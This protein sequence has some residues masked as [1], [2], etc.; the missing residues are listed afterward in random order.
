MMAG[1]CAQCGALL[2]A[3]ARFCPQCG[4]QAFSAATPASSGQRTLPPAMAASRGR[5]KFV[6][7]FFA[8]IVVAAIAVWMTGRNAKQPVQGQHAADSASSPEPAKPTSSSSPAEPALTSAP[9]TPPAVSYPEWKAGLA[10]PK[11]PLA[12]GL[13]VVTAIAHPSAGDYE[14]IKRIQSVSA[15]AIQIAYSSDVPGEAPPSGNASAA[16]PRRS[17]IRTV[18]Q[19]DLKKASEYHE[20]FCAGN[21][22]A[23]PGTTAI[24]IS[25]QTL[26]ELKK[27]SAT[28]KYQA[29]ENGG[30]ADQTCELKRVETADVSIPVLINDRRDRLPAVHARCTTKEKEE[31]SEFYVLD[32]PDNPLVL[33][34]QLG[35]SNKLQV[36]KITVPEDVPEIEQSLQQTGRAEVYGIYFD[37]GSASIR[38]ESAPVLK[39]ISDALAKNPAWK[40]SIEG[41]TDNVGGDGYNLDLSNRRAQAVKLALVSQYHVDA[42]RLA[43]AGFGASRPKETNDTLEG[44]A[45]NRRVELVRPPS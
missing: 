33:A 29:T 15:E 30:P 32:Q 31:D 21:D 41:H 6:I 44:R 25:M 13:T 10:A 1:R 26:A 14:S 35:F 27:G 19:Q 7:F 12:E 40:L 17:C 45:R 3:D 4:A 22:E 36:I 8:L 37:F 9:G 39:Q 20:N 38:P 5:G 23:Y 18:Q 16:P 43:T 28:I 2:K 11:V 42:S 34:W 24:S